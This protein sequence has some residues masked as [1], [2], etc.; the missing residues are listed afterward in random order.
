MGGQA[1]VLYGAAEFNRDTDIAVLAEAENLEAFMRA[2]NDLDAR[3]IAV[4]PFAQD[5]LLRGHAVLFRCEREDVRGMRVDAL[6]VMRGVAPFAELWARRTTLEWEGGQS[7]EVMSLPD[8]VQTKKTQRDKDWPML[9]RL[10][11]AHFARHAGDPI[12]E[13]VRF[14]FRESRTPSMLL[15]LSHRY[16]SVAAE[17]AATRPLLAT[18]A[19]GD[20]AALT[21]DLELEEKREREA[22]RAYWL[23]LKRE[24]EALRRKRRR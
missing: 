12:D 14:W 5:A 16:A 22:D 24:L 18:A 23:P 9:R 21:T 3:S 20:E 8:L 6:S 7:L 19:K 17:L 13:H 10:V 15:E 1:C 4:P 2:L 11:E